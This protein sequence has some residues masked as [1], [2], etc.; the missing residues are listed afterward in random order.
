MIVVVVEET[1]TPRFVPTV[2]LRVI[3]W[4]TAMICMAGLL[5]LLVMPIMPLLQILRVLRHPC[6]DEMGPLTI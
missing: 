6:Q 3:L 4:I 2:V 1:E 5:L